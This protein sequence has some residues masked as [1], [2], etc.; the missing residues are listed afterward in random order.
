MEEPKEMQNATT[1]DILTPAGEETIQSEQTPETLAETSAEN[2]QPAADNNKAEETTDKTPVDEQ[3]N[4]ETI[5]PANEPAIE[6]TAENEQSSEPTSEA[7]AEIEEEPAVDYSGLSREELIEALKE[8]LQNDDITKIK[9]RVGAIKL[10]FAEADH[11]AKKAA[12]DRFIEEGGNKDEYEASDDAVAEAYRK[13]Y[14]IYRERRQKHIDEVEAA[15]KH[16]LELKQ[17][18]LDELRKLIDDES[19]SLKQSYDQFNAIQERW[20][21]IGEVPRTELNGLWQTYHFL[22]EQFFNKVKINKELMLLDQKK[23]LES[24][25]LLC[26]KAEELIVEPSIAK[27]AK[28]LQSLREQ[29]REI[30]PVPVEQN[31]EIWTRFRNAASQIDERR[32]EYYEQRREEM[33]K[34]LLAK[35]ALIEKAIE[36]TT[37]TPTTTKQWN[38]I[39]AQLD[40][41]LKVWKSIGPVPREQNEEIWKTFKGRIDR[42]YAEKKQ[43]FDSVKDEQSENYN[44]K[45]DLCLQAEAIAKRD[46]WKKATEELLKLQEEWK[47]IG[48]VNRKVSEKIWQRFRSACDEF[49][50]RKSE[51]FTALRGSE[52]ENLEKKEALL[53]ELKAY[54]FGDDKDENLTAIKDF[55]RRWMEIGH[56]PIAEKQRLQKEF[57]ETINAMFEKLKITAR[58]AELASF[59]E[60]LHNGKG[61]HQISDKREHLIEQIQKL[62]A[63]LNLWENNL[64]FLAD[65]KQA[66]LLKAEFEKKMQSARQEIALLEAKLKIIDSENNKAEEGKADD[67]NK[68]E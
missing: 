61:G 49:F 10:R 23:N 18:I 29:W 68:A 67:G 6:N 45:I 7:E 28:E 30:G 60:T 51:Y 33:E 58:E 8:L 13:T 39:S 11:E 22:I 37:E 5:E 2:C 25:T 34:N 50:A 57:R 12:F 40:E 20:K 65:S 52:Q 43:Y 9:N 66:E 21:T 46:D 44:R 41:L 42:F 16:N 62:R 19:E 32:R 35:Q 59:R 63:D 64:G 55:Q 56:V 48:P 17:Q 27:A 24:K 3:T 54:S 36:L 26:E 31:D 14:S 4:V 1:E 38:D 53:A 47:K 15:K